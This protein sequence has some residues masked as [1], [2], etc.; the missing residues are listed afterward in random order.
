MWPI[1]FIPVVYDNHLMSGETNQTTEML[2]DT[3][4]I[5]RGLAAVGVVGILLF[6][7]VVVILGLVMPE[8]SA[9]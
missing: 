9:V 6:W 5:V 2:G 7:L 4:S 8:D 3:H 1:K